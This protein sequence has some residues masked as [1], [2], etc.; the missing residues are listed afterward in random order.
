MQ[1]AQVRGDQTQNRA[2]E[3]I[4]VAKVPQHKS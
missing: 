2:K 1:S 4:M 3:L